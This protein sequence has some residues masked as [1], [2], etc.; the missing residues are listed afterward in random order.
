MR[1]R[2]KKINWLILFLFFFVSVGAQ[3]DE[4]PKWY[5]RIGY[6]VSDTPWTYGETLPMVHTKILGQV[7]RF[8]IIDGYLSPISHIGWQTGLTAL[9]DYAPIQDK[10]WHLYQ[11]LM[12]LMAQP[13]NKAN[14][15]EM[16]VYR[17]E[18]SI[19]PVWRVMRHK[20][21]SVDVAPLLNT[22]LQGNLK[23]SN[24]NNYGNVKG[25][26]GL[27]GWARVRYVLPWKV[28]KI[29]LSYSAQLSLLHAT[30][31]PAFGQSYYDY[32]S[33]G[34][35]SALKFHLTS[36]HNNITFRQRLLVDFPIHRLTV[37]LGAEHYHQKQYL[38]NTRFVQGYWGVVMGISFDTFT[39]SGGRS[40]RSD[41]ISSTLY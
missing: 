18:F 5:D 4:R 37:T 3:E 16:D 10:S 8:G 25:S 35:G 29:A 13:H 36:L 41:V 12:L 30:F 20:G 40:T 1:S 28:S 15:T 11:E 7:G 32:V 22:Q 6:W 24:T 14:N 2:M 23:N 31:H 19:G 9:T 38:S 17:G 26:I 21:I 39:L 34:E 33:G 27:D